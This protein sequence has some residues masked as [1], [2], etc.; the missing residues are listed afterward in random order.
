VQVD[1]EGLTPQTTDDKEARF[2]LVAGEGDGLMLGIA[3]GDAAG[4]AWEL[5]YSAITEQATVIAYELIQHRRIDADSLRTALRDLDGSADEEPV[6]RSET[7]HFREWLDLTASGRSAPADGP[8]LDGIPRATVVGVCFRRQPDHVIRE[9]VALTRMFDRDSSSLGAALISAT[10]A[11]ASCFGQAGR[12]LI[13]GVIEAVTPTLERLGAEFSGADRLRRLPDELQGLVGHIGVADGDEALEMVGGDITDPLQAVQAALL[14]VAPINDRFHL[15]VEQ[16]ARIGGSTLGAFAGGI[17][18]ARVGIK[19][20]PWAFANDTWF[21]EI[22]RRLV[23]GPDDIEGLPIPYA[24][25]QHLMF[26]PR[27]GFH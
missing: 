6:Y 8:N 27:P 12:D 26:G 3:A 17:M 24:V 25:E 14:L 20:W 21:A 2:S 9:T 1:T 22:G 19:A 10:S 15:P 11:A 18:G 7:S 23:R 4:G 16:A 13:A 5:G